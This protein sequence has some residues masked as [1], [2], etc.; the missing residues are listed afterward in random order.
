M[1]FISLCIISIGFMSGNGNIESWTF[2]WQS[3]SSYVT[4]F[5]LISFYLKIFIRSLKCARHCG[6]KHWEYKDKSESLE[7]DIKHI[8]RDMIKGIPKCWCIDFLVGDSF[9][10]S[11]IH[12]PIHPSIY[13]HMIFPQEHERTSCRHDACW[14][15]NISV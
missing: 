13:A 2:L 3:L 12:S 6:K 5:F 9:R 15:L 4:V 10:P 7:S 1:Y 11:S 8:K 14:L